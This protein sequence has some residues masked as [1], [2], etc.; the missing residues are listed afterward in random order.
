MY[1]NNFFVFVTKSQQ[2]KI[3]IDAF[4]TPAYI[5]FSCNCT[6]ISLDKTHLNYSPGAFQV[7]VDLKF[8]WTCNYQNSVQASTTIYLVGLL[9]IITEHSKTSNGTSFRNFNVV[10]NENL[11][12]L[13]EQV[14][15]AFDF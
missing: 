9:R 7:S 2:L 12:H 1:I 4:R 6:W 3:L 11:A 13:T 15:H 14:I 8:T 5:P 10:S